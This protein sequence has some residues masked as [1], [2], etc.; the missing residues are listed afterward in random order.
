MLKRV[1]VKDKFYILMSIHECNFSILSFALCA[2][3]FESSRLVVRLKL[4]QNRK[5][6]MFLSH[7]NEISGGR[8]NICLVSG[9]LW[10]NLNFLRM[11]FFTARFCGW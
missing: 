2:F 11:T 10:R 8:G 1:S 4:V 7:L 9:S 5:L 6:P 3:T